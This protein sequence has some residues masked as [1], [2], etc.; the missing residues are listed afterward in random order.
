MSI[1]GASESLVSA[2][3]VKIVLVKMDLVT[4]TYVEEVEFPVRIRSSA[5]LRART[6][7]YA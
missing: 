1:F 6:G 5:F 3:R 2:V 7:R 4:D